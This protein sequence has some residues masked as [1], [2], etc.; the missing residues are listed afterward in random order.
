MSDRSDRFGTQVGRE[1]RS[2]FGETRVIWQQ[3]DNSHF[4]SLL[5]NHLQLSS[6]YT[7]RCLRADSRWR[8]RR[9]RDAGL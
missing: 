3:L 1:P 9:V 7:N 4:Q 5:F 8:E 6:G 2:Q